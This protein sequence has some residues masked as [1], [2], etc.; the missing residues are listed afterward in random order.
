MWLFA[1]LVLNFDEAMSLIFHVLP[2]FRIDVVNA[3]SMSKHRSEGI[4]S[5]QLHLPKPADLGKSRNC[6]ICIQTC[7]TVVKFERRLGCCFIPIQTFQHAILGYM[8]AI[9]LPALYINALI[10]WQSATPTPW[11]MYISS[12]R[13]TETLWVC[14]AGEHV[15]G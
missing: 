5:S 3:C 6:M 10:T 12:V 1:H 15:N 14:L 4:M 11:T 7:P 8:V 9:R 13:Y 2:W